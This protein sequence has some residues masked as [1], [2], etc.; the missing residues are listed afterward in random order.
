VD[1]DELGRAFFGGMEMDFVDDDGGRG[2]GFDREKSKGEGEQPV[3]S[4]VLTPGRVGRERQEKVV[5]SKRMTPAT[6]RN[7]DEPKDS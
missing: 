1:F 7:A 2:R 5:D 3:A 6:G 4:K